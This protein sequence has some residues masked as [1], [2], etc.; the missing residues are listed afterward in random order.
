[1]NVIVD[2]SVLIKALLGSRGVWAILASL[3]HSFYAPQVILDEIRRH[4][5]IICTYIHAPLEEFDAALNSLGGF[6][7][8]VDPD[9]YAQY[10]AKA[11]T[12][13]ESRDPSDADYVA[14]A[15]SIGA[16]FIWTEDKDF[17]A[18]KLARVKTTSQFID[19][20]KQGEPTNGSP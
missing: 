4:K 9:S 20:R 12:S 14:A 5:A 13:M 7:Q 11:K 15:I 2:A 3:N 19:E 17:S 10:L 8:I 18:Q 1:M 16:D 6:V